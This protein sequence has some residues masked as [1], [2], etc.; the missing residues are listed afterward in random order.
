[1][2]EG[3][4][5]RNEI[6]K[7]KAEGGKIKTLIKDIEELSAPDPSSRKELDNKIE[8]A[9]KYLKI[10]KGFAMFSGATKLSQSLEEILAGTLKTT[11]DSDPAT[12]QRTAAILK[13][14]DSLANAADT[15]QT[16]P[17]IKRV[18][19]LLI[20]IIELR[21]KRD[22]AMLD[23][24]L[25]EDSLHIYEAQ[26][27]ARL[28]EFA[29]LS[30]TKLILNELQNT[31]SLDGDGGGFAVIPSGTKEPGPAVGSMLATYS[32]SWNQGQ[33]PYE[34]LQFKEEQIKRAYYVD[35]AALTAQNMNNLL[36][37]ALDELA[38]YGKGGI[39]P[40]TIATLITNLGLIAA[41]AAR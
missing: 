10:I 41:F 40:E 9:Q 2:D 31:I 18:N 23:I 14:T 27:T 16:E 33:I 12:A 29:Q 39:H 37:P 15:F 8:E 19:S 21:Q 32:A 22:M 26:Q 11:T 17:K 13:L 38:A 5:I 1:M 7:E 34:I 30:A 24:N 36:I 35:V 25:K 6:E 4:N 28:Y 3:N 20:A